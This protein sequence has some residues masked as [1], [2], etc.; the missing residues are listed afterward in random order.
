MPKEYGVF[1]HAPLMGPARHC[2][3]A[4][5]GER[6]F[7]TTGNGVDERRTH[8]PAPDAPA[9]VCIEKNTG[10]TLW[11]D[12][13]P[14]GNVMYTEAANPLVAEIGG[15]PQVIVPQGD[16]WLRSFDPISGTVLWKFDLNR[17][18]AILEL[19][20]RGTKNYSPRGARAARRAGLC[21]D[22]SG[23]RT[24]RGPGPAALH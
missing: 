12:K 9:L 22:R 14:G 3:I 10:K 4:A 6:I 5:H 13:S 16:G 18:D 17:K 20:G 1:P 23:S 2:S 8:V 24:W 21:D 15:L 11:T 7:V 19:G